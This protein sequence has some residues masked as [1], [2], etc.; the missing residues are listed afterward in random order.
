M[1][2][3]PPWLAFTLASVALAG[4]VYA[5]MMQSAYAFDRHPGVSLEVWRQY[6]PDGLGYQATRLVNRSAQDK[7]AWTSQQDS[8]VLRSGE[9]WDLGPLPAPGGV[10][11]TN[12]QGTDPGCVNARRQYG[13][14]GG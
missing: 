11:V 9:T 5:P 4:C 7:C 8:R 2:T 3:A 12:V 14:P 1:K 13:V 6:T 10:G